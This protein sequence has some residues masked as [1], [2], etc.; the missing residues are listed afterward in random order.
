MLRINDER[1]DTHGEDK[2]ASM[3][4]GFLSRNVGETFFLGGGLPKKKKSP[5]VC[6]SSCTYVVY[7]HRE[8]S[9]F[10]HAFC[11]DFSFRP[12]GGGVGWGVSRGFFLPPSFERQ[13]DWHGQEPS[14]PSQR[15]RKS[16]REDEKRE[17]E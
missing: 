3:Q 7:G 9:C 2:T 16:S 10:F 14:F 1:P 11:P 4:A 5:R 6:S 13:S 8:N 15:K 17:R 12:N